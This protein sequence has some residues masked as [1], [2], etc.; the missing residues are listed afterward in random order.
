MVKIFPLSH[1]KRSANNVVGIVNYLG[2]GEKKDWFVSPGRMIN[3]EKRVLFPASNI[4][5]AGKGKLARKKGLEM[6]WEGL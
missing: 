6:S 3:R 4:L 2:Q 1:T 5:K